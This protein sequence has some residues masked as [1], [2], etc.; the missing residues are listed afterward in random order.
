MP[1]D[2]ELNSIKATKDLFERRSD[3]YSDRPVIPLYE[4]CVLKFPATSC[5]L[6]LVPCS[7]IETLESPLFVTASTSSAF[8]ILVFD[9]LK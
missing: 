2:S 8:G 9:Q 5:L 4:M 7:L 3:F 1:N 6:Q